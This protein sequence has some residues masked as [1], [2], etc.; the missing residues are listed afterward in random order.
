MKGAN[1]EESK[2]WST[3]GFKKVGE[4]QE[5]TSPQKS[6]QSPDKRGREPENEDNRLGEPKPKQM[7]QS[8]TNNR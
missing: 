4:Q 7:K 8:P 6:S 5:T 2:G 1:K 3:G